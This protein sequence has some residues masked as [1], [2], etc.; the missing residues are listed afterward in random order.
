MSTERWVFLVMKT[1]FGSTAD[2]AQV[3][4]CSILMRGAKNATLLS[5][6]RSGKFDEAEFDE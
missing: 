1:G 6:V 5:L 2:G 4:T 3:A